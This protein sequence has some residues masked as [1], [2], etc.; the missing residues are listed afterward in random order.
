M[1]FQVVIT[2][3][4]L[5]EHGVF[6]FVCFLLVCVGFLG[7]FLGLLLLFFFWGGFVG[8]VGFLFVVVCLL[9][10]F[11]MIVYCFVGILLLVFMLLLLL[12]FV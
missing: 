8:F 1:S 4:I 5:S 10:G 2:F 6:L 11:C 7:F 3:K 9:W 12:F